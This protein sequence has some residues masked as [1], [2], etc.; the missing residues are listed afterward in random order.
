MER[1]AQMGGGKYYDAT[2]KHRSTKHSETS[3]LVSIPC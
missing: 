2:V 3:H 1:V